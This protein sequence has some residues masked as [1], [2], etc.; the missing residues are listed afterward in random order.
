MKKSITASPFEWK[1]STDI[2]KHLLQL[3]EFVHECKHIRNKEIKIKERKKRGA[4]GG[5]Q[6]HLKI[7]V[8]GRDLR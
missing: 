2:V 8:K 4:N 5:T 7:R 1:K 6:D 3:I